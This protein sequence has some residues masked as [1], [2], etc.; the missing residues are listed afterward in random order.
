VGHDQGQILAYAVRVALPDERVDGEQPGVELP[1]RDQRHGIR[2]YDTAAGCRPAFDERH[3]R[4]SCGRSDVHAAPPVAAGGD[5]HL[6]AGDQRDDGAS[7]LGRLAGHGGRRTGRVPF[8]RS[9]RTDRRAGR[10]SRDRENDRDQQCL[11]SMASHRVSPFVGQY[12][13]PPHMCPRTPDRFP[14]KSRQVG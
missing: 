6:V 1:G 4:A 13:R 9:G 8:R 10:Q 7:P 3:A 2:G 12:A 14:R 11:P 5:D